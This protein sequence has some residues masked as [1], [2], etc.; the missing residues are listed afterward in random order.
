MG[1][2]HIGVLGVT[3][4]GLGVFLGTGEEQ[5][6][7]Q[8]AKGK[9]RPA[10]TRFLMKGISQPHCKGLGELLKDS[11]PADEKAWEGVACHSSCL[12]ELSFSLVQDG[13]CPDAA[14]AGAAKS[15]GEGSAA[16]LGA[17]EKKDLEGARTAFKTV[18]E[19]CKSCHDAHKKPK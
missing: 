2:V 7:A 4:L 1:R 3:A 12:N 8:V 6:G 5:A 15:L 18:T 11:G 17:V 9:T 19:S 13:R 14:W 10:A 16:L